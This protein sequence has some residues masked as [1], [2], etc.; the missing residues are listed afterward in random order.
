MSQTGQTGCCLDL[1]KGE[2]CGKCVNCQSIVNGEVMDIMEIDAASNRGI[3]DVRNLKESSYLMPVSLPKKVFIVDEVHMLTKEAFNA[4]LKVIEEP[5]AHVMFILCTTDEEKIPDTVLSRLV[6][7]EFR[8]G[9]KNELLKSLERV[10]VGEELELSDETKEFIVGK[11]DGS[12]RNLQKSL[13]EIVLEYG[14]KISK[15]NVMEY[16][17]RKIGDYSAE[18]LE[19][20]LNNANLNIILE[21]L[22]KLADKGI[23]FVSLRENWLEYFHKKLLSDWRQELVDWVERLVAASKMEKEIS[24]EQLPL[25]LAVIEFLKDKKVVK[26]IEVK[27]KVEAQE[28]IVEEHDIPGIVDMSTIEENWNNFLIEVKP[29]NHSV[30]AFLRATRPKKVKSNTLVVEVFYPFHKDKLEESKN[31]EIVEMCL[32]KVIGKKMSVCCILAKDRKKPLIIQND[33]PVEKVN[34]QLAVE[35]KADDI[36]NAAKDIFG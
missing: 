18:E 5:P 16:F 29:H 36:Y 19:T 20:D 24:I 28:V 15:E 12:F 4:L 14:K 25:E 7:I 2:A 13:N 30:E 11:S 21:K 23:N 9:A 33:T 32:T 3:E 27:E 6:K 34:D 17:S 1:Q 10:I 22:E 8:R 31:K 35:K 26:N